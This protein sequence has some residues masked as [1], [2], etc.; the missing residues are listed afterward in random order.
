MGTIS[1]V[2]AI[3]E[4]MTPITNMDDSIHGTF[5]CSY[6]NEAMSVGYRVPAKPLRFELWGAHE[7]L[8][9]TDPRPKTSPR[10]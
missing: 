1:A 7:D 9:P 6:L 5:W 2:N 8:P 4:G 3:V 10:I